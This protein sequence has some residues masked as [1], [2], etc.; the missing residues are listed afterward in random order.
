MLKHL[1]S[2]ALLISSSTSFANTQTLGFTEGPVPNFYALACV[3]NDTTSYVRVQY[4][5]NGGAWH[6][7][8][9][10][11][12]YQFSSSYTYSFPNENRS[13]E[14]LVVLRT[15]MQGDISYHTRAYASPDQ[16]C[17]HGKTIHIRQNGPNF[18]AEGEELYNGAPE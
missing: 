15:Q 6:T 3:V 13:P 14:F 18:W 1:F 5:W 9:L 8:D 4:G 17:A 16:D 12:N 11:P 10:A 7:T 2:L